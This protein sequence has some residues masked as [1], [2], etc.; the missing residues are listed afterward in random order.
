MALTES[1]MLPLGTTA[2]SFTLPDVI[3]GQDKSFNDIRGEK[4]TVVMFICNHCPFVVH[5]NDEVVALAN[6]YLDKGVGFVGISSNDVEN[7]PQDSP[8][9]MSIVAKVLKYPFPYLYD[10]SQEV[11]KAYDAA[12]TP[13]FYIFNSDDVLVYRGR[14][15]SSRP[16]NGVPLTGSDLR[17]AIEATLL[18]IK[19]ISPQLPSAGC[20]IKWK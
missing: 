15:D 17:F 10:A 2:P 13:D 7:Y 18:G 11:A 3:S 20:N 19:E 14:L 6:Q 8:D 1:N 16:G 5:V 9:K 4:A 12:C